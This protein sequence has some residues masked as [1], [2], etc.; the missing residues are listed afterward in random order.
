MVGNVAS[1][2]LWDQ[3]GSTVRNAY[4]VPALSFGIWVEQIIH[5][6]CNINRKWPLKLGKSLNL[7]VGRLVKGGIPFWMTIFVS[8]KRWGMDWNGTFMA[9]L[10]WNSSCEKNSLHKFRCQILFCV[11]IKAHHTA[12]R[13]RLYWIYEEFMSSI[14][15]GARWAPTTYKWS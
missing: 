3:V 6:W 14:C 12:Y 5:P 11:G 9:H 8:K 2:W 13:I 4:V 15:S 7:I 1:N 10:L